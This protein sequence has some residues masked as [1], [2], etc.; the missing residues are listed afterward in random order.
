MALTPVFILL[1]AYFMYK[2]RVTVPE[3]IG[4]VVSVCGVALFFF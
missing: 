1:P 2:Q 4:S 3:L